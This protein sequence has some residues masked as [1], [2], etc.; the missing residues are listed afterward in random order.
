MDRS[1]VLYTN[2]RDFITKIFPGCVVSCC[3]S[4]RLL[5]SALFEEV[6]LSQD[7][8]HKFEKEMDRKITYKRW[9]QQRHNKY[10]EILKHL[11]N[12]IGKERLLEIL[13]KKSLISFTH[14][15]YYATDLRID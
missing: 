7:D 13:K 6:P 9:M 2:R 3:V 5:G 14:T 8:E 11:E 15:D 4:Q 10:I 1:N 12:D